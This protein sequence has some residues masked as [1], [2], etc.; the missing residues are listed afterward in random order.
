MVHAP[1]FPQWKEIEIA[2]REFLHPILWH[3]QPRTSEWNFTNLFIWRKN[4]GFRWSLYR[5]WLLVLCPSGP[6]GIFALQPLGPPYRAEAARRLLR[7]L[8]EQGVEEP[9]IERADRRMVEEVAGETDLTAEPTRDHF[10]YVYRIQDLVQLSGRKYHAKK[11]HVNRFRQSYRFTYADLEESHIPECL[12]LSASWCE[13]RR[14]AEDQNL[15]REWEAVQGGLTHFRELKLRGGAILIEGRVEA[16]TFGERLNED[17]AVVHVEKAN[18]EIPGLYAMINQQFCERAWPPEI[19]YL[20]REQDLGQEGLRRAKLSYHPD[21]L[22][23]KFRLRFAVPK[24][25][26]GG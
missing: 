21:H 18:P 7:W 16:F 17:T 20:N 5:E 25:E 8:K 11:N 1:Q 4:Y 2:D 12:K 19:I 15:L 24:G 10:D 23:E 6:H 9:R 26:G 13:L 22:I 3:Y 14:C